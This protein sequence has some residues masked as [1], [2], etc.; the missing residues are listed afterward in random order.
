MSLRSLRQI[1]LLRWGRTNAACYKPLPT[2]LSHS[3]NL[4]LLGK[5]GSCPM[6]AIATRP[7]KSGRAAF[8]PIPDIPKTRSIAR[9]SDRERTARY[10]LK[11]PVYS[12][13][14]R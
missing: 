10:R 1:A 4:I 12:V 2:K 7:P 14:M 11:P 9:K 13:G 5:G 8:L 3:R 6:S